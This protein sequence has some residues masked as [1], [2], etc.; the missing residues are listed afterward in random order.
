MHKLRTFTNMILSSSLVMAS[1]VLHRGAALAFEYRT[2]FD[3]LGPADIETAHVLAGNAER[4]H[5]VSL[6]V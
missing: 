5:S 3:D 6:L 4:C 2:I 1:F